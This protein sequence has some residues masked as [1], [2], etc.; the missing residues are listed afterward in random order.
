MSFKIFANVYSDR[1]TEVRRAA[2][3]NGAKD[4]RMP[5]P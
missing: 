4:L 1:L 3:A 2:P 5:F